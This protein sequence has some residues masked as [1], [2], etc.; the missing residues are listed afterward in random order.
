MFFY[1]KGLGALLLLS[2]FPAAAFAPP[3]EGGGDPTTPANNVVPAP[4]VASPLLPT[5]ANSDGPILVPDVRIAN[6]GIVDGK[7]LRGEQ[8]RGEDYAALARL[9]VTTIVD[10][11]L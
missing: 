9:G 1:R 2:L 10:L 7:I 11:R 3:G 8:P 6:F 5:L 4:L